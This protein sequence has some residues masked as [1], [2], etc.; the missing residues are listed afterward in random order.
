MATPQAGNQHDTFEFER[1]F[2][3][4]YQPLKAAEL[5]LEGLSFN[6]EKAF[7]VS[8]WRQVCARRGTEV[9]IPRNRRAVNWQTDDDTSLDP[10]HYH[11]RLV[12]E[13]LCTWLTGFK[14]LLVRYENSLQN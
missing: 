4:L 5:R 8:N 9:N 10:E 3:E 14:A 7:N 12:I 13:R 6:A 1:V 2:A 11:H